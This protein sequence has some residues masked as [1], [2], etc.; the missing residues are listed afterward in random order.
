MI[1]LEDG[2]LVLDRRQD[3]DDIL[4]II[5]HGKGGKGNAWYID[6]GIAEPDVKNFLIDA[7]ILDEPF[8]IRYFAL[9]GQQAD[10]EAQIEE[11][12]SG[13]DGD[14]CRLRGRGAPPPAFLADTPKEI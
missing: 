8:P 4:P 13:P 2:V 3:G 14:L 1:T 5:H 9:D 10:A 6:L 12:I 11:L 7:E